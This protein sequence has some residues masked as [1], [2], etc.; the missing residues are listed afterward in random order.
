MEKAKILTEIV[1]IEAAGDGA[2]SWATETLK[3]LGKQF[4]QAMDCEIKIHSLRS[5]LENV[6]DTQIG[7]YIKVILKD[8]RVARFD[9][10]DRGDDWIRF[11][12]Y[13]CIV[14]TP[15]NENASNAGGVWSSDAQKCLKEKILPLLPYYLTSMI[16]ETER[17]FMNGGADDAAE[18]TFKTELFL[19]DAS[20]L[21]D[22]D[23]VWFSPVYEQMDYYKDRR[24]RIKAEAPGSTKMACWWTASTHSNNEAHIVMVSAYGLLSHS[25]A[26]IDDIFVPVCF[27]I[28]TKQK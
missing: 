1:N 5:M 20:E 13:D 10:T 16:I 18:E 11:D 12:S 6:E 14:E 24:N 25:K 21:F 23:D 15:W 26:S 22:R 2:M 9:V 27:R 28:S 8:G 17:R 7:D 3:E 4:V 19:P